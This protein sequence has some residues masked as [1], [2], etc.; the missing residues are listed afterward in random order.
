MRDASVW[1]EDMVPGEADP[2]FERASEYEALLAQGTRLSGEERL[3][4]VR[5]RV[6]DLVSHLPPGFVPR[7]ILDFGC[8]LGDTSRHLA[9]AFRGAD[10]VGVDSATSAL[11]WAKAHHAGARVAFGEMA[12]LTA[13]PAFDLCYVNG[14]LHHVPFERRAEVLETIRR[15]LRPR[16]LLALFE[17]NPWNVGARMVMRRI[18]FDRDAIPLSPRVAWRLLEENR[19]RCLAR[20]SLFY[21]PRVLS[22]LRP[23]E[24]ALA[25]VPLGAQYW[26]LARAWEAPEVSDVERRAGPR[27]GPLSLVA[28]GEE[29]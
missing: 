24:S 4:F 19:F 21:F 17:N 5:G 22:A 3:F 7:R 18:P 8:G 1:A 26:I 11:E 6:A 14:V 10:V 15:A 16:G 25:R 20:R 28:H 9:D 27:G 23:L 2:F 29:Q 13:H 12:A